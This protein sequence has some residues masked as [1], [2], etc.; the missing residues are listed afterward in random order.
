M[1]N[2]LNRLDYFCAVRCVCYFAVCGP[3]SLPVSWRGASANTKRV[4]DAGFFGG[5]A[6]GGGRPRQLG[7]PARAEGRMSICIHCNGW[8]CTRCRPPTVDDV[9]RLG[10]EQGPD[11]QDIEVARLRDELRTTKAHLP[12]AVT[13]PR[14]ALAAHQTPGDAADGRAAGR[15]LRRHLSTRRR[16]RIPR[17][18]ACKEE[19]MSIDKELEPVWAETSALIG[20]IQR[21]RRRP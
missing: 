14:H 11:A 4:R 1:A 2:S 8:N 10:G 17:G 7:R 3:E 20:K 5:V 21:S 19:A 18:A 16:P 13:R 12:A 6:G 9:A 15:G